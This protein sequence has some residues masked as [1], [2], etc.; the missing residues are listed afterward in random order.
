MARK[1]SIELDDLLDL[2][3]CAEDYGFADDVFLDAAA[4]WMGRKLSDAEIEEFAARYLTPEMEA[5]GYSEEDAGSTPESLRAFRDRYI[6][7]K[8]AANTH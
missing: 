1:L 4:E 7:P 6:T 2:V 3:N 8:P 5:K